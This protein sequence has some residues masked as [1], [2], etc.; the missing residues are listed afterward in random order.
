M[1]LTDSLPM[2]SNTLLT[3]LAWFLFLSVVLYFTRVPAH[4]AI[5]TLCRVLD[6]AMRLAS[7]SILGAE[8]RLAERNRDV[9]LAI[10]REAADAS[11]CGAQASPAMQTK[12][13]KR[14][15]FLIRV[16][17]PRSTSLARPR[18]RRTRRSRNL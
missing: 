10:G 16:P 3:G 1:S 17:R 11:P 8:K 14:R 12:A 6:E 13:S 18:A 4:R 9:L 15:D 5:V 2:F 7:G